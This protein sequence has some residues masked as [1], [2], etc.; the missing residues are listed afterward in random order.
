MSATFYVSTRTTEFSI[1]TCYHFEYQYVPDDLIASLVGGVDL[2]EKGDANSSSN[3][4]LYLLTIL[5]SK[6][7]FNSAKR[8]ISR[9]KHLFTR[10]TCCIITT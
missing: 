7:Y 6:K 8:S 1:H 5:Q 10:Y 4:F 2:S 3:H 9:V